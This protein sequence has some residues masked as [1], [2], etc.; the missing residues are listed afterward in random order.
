MA[1]FGATW[2]IGSGRSKDE[3]PERYRKG[4][5]SSV[6]VMQQENIQLQSQVQM[7]TTENAGIRTENTEIKAQ[8]TAI[9]EENAEIKAQL[10]AIMKKLGMK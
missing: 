1:N 4:P 9:M 7:L 6:Y 8:N 2:K 5:I 3:I 10:A